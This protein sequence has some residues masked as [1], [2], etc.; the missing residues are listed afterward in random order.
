MHPQ[1]EKVSKMVQKIRIQDYTYTL[2]EDRIAKFPLKNRDDSKLLLYI[3]NNI[4]EEKFLN[5]A[6]CLPK[7]GFMIFNNTKVVP[8]RLIFKRDSGA[9]IEVF[10]LEPDTPN[11]YQICFLETKMCRWKAIVGNVKRW[12]SGKLSLLT[13]HIYKKGIDIEYSSVGTGDY[14]CVDPENDANIKAKRHLSELQSINLQVELIE[15][16]DNETI[17]EFTW[18]GGYSF[19]K[20]MDTCGRIPIPPYLKRDSQLIDYERYQTYYASKE[21]SVAAPTAGLHFTDAVLKKIEKRGIIRDSLCLHVGAGTFL[22]VKSE[23]IS[24]HQMHSEPFSV[25]LV[26]LMNLLGHSEGKPVISVGTTSTRCLESL[27]FLG[28]QCIENGEPGFVSQ[29]EPYRESG[30]K[31]TLK[32][33]V[34][35]LIKYMKDI[36]KNIFT[37]RTSIII[38]PGYKFRVINYMVTNFH[39][40]QST[41]LLLIAAFIGDNNWREVYNFALSHNFRFLS[42]GDSSLLKLRSECI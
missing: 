21:G 14:N 33:S 37:S 38:V 22:P 26:F 24:D 10:C 34:S 2:P 18:D 4:R 13:D 35:A 17:V 9:I 1:R 5:I 40:P 30:Y 23:F 32:E 31:Y 29:W 20:V 16:K 41:L 7:N 28:V 42:Y 12:K 15:R 36:N 39:Q 25:S 11:D 27:Y 8:A 3:D 6:D 19:S